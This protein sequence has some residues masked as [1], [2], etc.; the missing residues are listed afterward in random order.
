MAITYLSGERI[1][2]N[3]L[4]GDSGWVTSDS[5]YLNINTTTLNLIKT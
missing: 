2:G 1:Q 5:T 4:T 3:Y